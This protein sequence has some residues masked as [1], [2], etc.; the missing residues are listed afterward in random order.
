MPDNNCTVMLNDL[1]GLL[2][3]L[4]NAEKVFIADI[5]SFTARVFKGFTRHTAKGYSDHKSQITWRLTY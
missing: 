4:V 5:V 1:S 2:Q 3:Q